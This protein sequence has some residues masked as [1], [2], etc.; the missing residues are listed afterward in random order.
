MPSHT[1]QHPPNLTPP[2]TLSPAFACMCED[3]QFT[4]LS[5]QCH[6]VGMFVC[7]LQEALACKAITACLLMLSVSCAC[8]FVLQ[9]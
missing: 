9:G 6:G 2:R 1:P 4:P 7:M 5:L 8:V 3:Y